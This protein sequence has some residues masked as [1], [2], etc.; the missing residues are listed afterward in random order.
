MRKRGIRGF[1]AKDVLTGAVSATSVQDLDNRSVNS[2]QTVS[3]VID[4]NLTTFWN[5]ATPSAATYRLLFNFSSSVRFTRVTIQLVADTTHDPTGLT[6]FTDSTKTTQVGS[7][8][9]MRGRATTT[10]TLTTPYVGNRMYMEFAKST[11]FQLY[12]EEVQFNQ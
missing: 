11:S 9:D 7:F 4:G 10:V 3:R 2:G 8:G 12:L 1:S 5:P 6:I